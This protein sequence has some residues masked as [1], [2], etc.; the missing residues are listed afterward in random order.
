MQR[1]HYT[2]AGDTKYKLED[3]QASTIDR[4]DADYN[5]IAVLLGGVG[6][7]ATSTLV[8]FTDMNAYNIEC[9][10]YTGIQNSVMADASKRDR[11]GKSAP[12][13]ECPF[14]HCWLYGAHVVGKRERVPIIIGQTG[15]V[16]AATNRPLQLV[17]HSRLRCQ[18][19]VIA[20]TASR[21][22]PPALTVSMPGLNLSR[23]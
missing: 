4:V 18:P 12:L 7:N 3:T 19:D 23:C 15:T 5:H 11:P 6:T 9:A 10:D 1:P 17:H 2:R 13:R 16:A 8:R 20:M 14:S 21:Q 22:P